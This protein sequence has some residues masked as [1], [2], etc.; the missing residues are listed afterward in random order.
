ME[1]AEGFH[2]K[3]AAYLSAF[4]EEINQLGKVQVSEAR[5]LS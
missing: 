3:K 2:S 1:C 4:G 5:A